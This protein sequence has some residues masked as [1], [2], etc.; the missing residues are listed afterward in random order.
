MYFVYLY[1]Q[2]KT[3][4]FWKTFPFVSLPKM[5]LYVSN[6]KDARSFSLSF[7]FFFLFLNLR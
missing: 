1:S 3:V 7:F 4:L 2:K 6:V 5:V